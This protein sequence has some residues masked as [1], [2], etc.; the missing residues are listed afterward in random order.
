MSLSRRAFLT[1]AVVVPGVA[2]AAKAT[3]TPH[4]GDTLMPWMSWMSLDRPG[5]GLHVIA[6]MRASGVTSLAMNVAYY[7]LQRGKKVQFYTDESANLTRLLRYPHADRL[8]IN[9]A[10]CCDADVV[11]YD[12]ERSGYHANMMWDRS[13]SFN[14]PIYVTSHI[15]R[16]V[17]GD[18]MG[19]YIAGSSR[20]LMC[21]DTATRIAPISVGTM[22][23][24]QIKH[25]Y[26]TEHRSAYFIWT[27]NPGPVGPTRFVKMG[28][29]VTKTPE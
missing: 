12:V 6:G 23:L 15:T 3:P 22:E 21:A 29:M 13:R 1:A 24:S 19:Q 7:H 4:I 27:S 5:A 20:L 14:I 8:H 2:L 17:K 9:G 26:N 16:P 10:F 18:Q 25:R 11:V 28:I